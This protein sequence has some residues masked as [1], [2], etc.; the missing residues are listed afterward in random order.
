MGE[1]ICL[2]MWKPQVDFRNHFLLLHFLRQKVSHLNS[3]LTDL[4]SLACCLFWRSDSLRLLGLKLQASPSH[5]RDV[6]EI[7]TVLP[8]LAWQGQSCPWNMNRNMNIYFRIVCKKYMSVRLTT[9]LHWLSKTRSK[10]G[11]ILS[12][13]MDA[14]SWFLSGSL[15]AYL[16]HCGHDFMVLTFS[17]AHVAS[18]SPHHSTQDSASFG[19]KAGGPTHCYRC[20]F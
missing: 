11:L 4:A 15:R 10:R 13:C 14:G 5:L 20:Y 16:S 7:Q 12:V 19:R 8:R 18:S 6:L 2:W 17:W 3:E 9:L 1:P